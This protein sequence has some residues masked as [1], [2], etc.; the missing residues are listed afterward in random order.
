VV[1]GQFNGAVHHLF[2]GQVADRTLGI[3]LFNRPQRRDAFWQRIRDDV[4][5]FQLL[6]KARETV[7]A[8]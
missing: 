8:V 2:R 7:Y 5:V 3:P 6:D 1:G 4:A